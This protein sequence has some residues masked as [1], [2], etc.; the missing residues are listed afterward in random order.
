[1][2]IEEKITILQPLFLVQSVVTLTSKIQTKHQ[3]KSAQNELSIK[4]LRKTILVV[5]SQIFF[6]TL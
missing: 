5:K 6:P 1:V 2:K 4:L 3:G